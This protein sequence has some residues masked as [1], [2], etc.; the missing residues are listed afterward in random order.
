[1]EAGMKDS[2]IYA[3]LL[4]ASFRRV[5]PAAM[6][7]R[8]LCPGAVARQAEMGRQ[9]VLNALRGT[10]T[11]TLHTLARISHGLGMSFAELAACFDPR[12]GPGRR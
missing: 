5:L 10:N 8:R 6:A 11:P 2:I 7:E 4:C 3:D 9:V 12:H 1:M